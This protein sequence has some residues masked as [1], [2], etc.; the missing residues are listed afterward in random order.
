MIVEIIGGYIHEYEKRK[1]DLKKKNFNNNR[2][3]SQRLQVG[4]GEE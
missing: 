3:K 4:L 2:H 1:Y